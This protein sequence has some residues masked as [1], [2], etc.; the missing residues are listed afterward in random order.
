ME[1]MV[2]L[3]LVVVMEAVLAL[4]LAVHQRKQATQKL[5]DTETLVVL[6]LEMPFLFKL[7]EV[8]ELELQVLQPYPGLELVVPA[9]LVEVI[10]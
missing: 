10:Q 9:V 1:P 8:V 6:V 4:F 7:V 5:L 3:V 2:D